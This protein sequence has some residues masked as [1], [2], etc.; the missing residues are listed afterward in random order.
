MGILSAMP[1]YWRGSLFSKLHISSS[2]NQLKKPL[3]Y[4]VNVCI[5]RILYNEKYFK[6]FIPSI[7][8]LFTTILQ[9]VK[10]KTIAVQNVCIYLWFELWLIRS[11]ST[12]VMNITVDCLH[13]DVDWLI[14]F[15]TG[16]LTL[17]IASFGISTNLYSLKIIQ[18]LEIRLSIRIYLSVHTAANF[19]ISSCSVLYYSLGEAIRPIFG[20]FDEFQ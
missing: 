2:V 17:L 14:W 13:N 11:N 6:Q 16:P 18:S 15:I 7:Q 1:L 9:K 10:I 19:A 8:H 12:D 3:I 20:I 5:I 4:H